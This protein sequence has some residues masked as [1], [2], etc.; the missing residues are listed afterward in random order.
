M[1]LSDEIFKFVKGIENIEPESYLKKIREA[2][3]SSQQVKYAK[4]LPND[5]YIFKAFLDADDI[6]IKVKFAS[7]FKSNE[8]RYKAIENIV[9]SIKASLMESS[10]DF[11]SSLI[12]K[13]SIEGTKYINFNNALRIALMMQ[14][15]GNYKFAKAILDLMP[16]KAYR[17]SLIEKNSYFGNWKKENK[18]YENENDFLAELADSLSDEQIEELNKK[19]DSKKI[20][21][22]EELLK[23]SEEGE[24]HTLE[25]LKL[26]NEIKSSDAD[27][28]RIKL[29]SA[30]EDEGQKAS[31]ITTISDREKLINAVSTY[32]VSIN[33]KATVATKVEDF[34]TKIELIEMI[35]ID[36]ENHINKLQEEI[37]EEQNT[38]VKSSREFE[39]GSY[40][41][42]VRGLIKEIENS[43]FTKEYYEYKS[44]LGDRVKG[45]LDNN[46]SKIKDDA[47]QGDAQDKVVSENDLRTNDNGI[48]PSDKKTTGFFSWLMER[49]NKR[50]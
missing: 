29:L 49:L 19:M 33:M 40:I 13:G 48:P 24:D 41:I 6:D 20:E 8:Y 21:K 28:Y 16:E 34:D 31:I 22:I 25:I 12:E 1:A 27:D 37:N 46:R 15:D 50:R 26:L 39:L 43:F 38:Y 2:S 7:L 9:N 5:E 14:D 32:I 3:N 44:K 30:V 18:D 10:F 45:V 42:N 36:A 35:L 17:D 47:P 23:R 11:F 4:K